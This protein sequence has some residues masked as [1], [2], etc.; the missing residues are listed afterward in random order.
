MLVKSLRLQLAAAIAMLAVSSTALA[1][2]GLSGT[3][4]TTVRS[5]AQLAGKWTITFANASR[6]ATCTGVSSCRVPSLDSK[7]TFRP[8]TSFGYT[9]R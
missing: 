2:G 9:L 6:N 1:A 5:P 3:Y 7:G 4:T 8:A